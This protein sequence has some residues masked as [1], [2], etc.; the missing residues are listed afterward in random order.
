MLKKE[1]QTKHY[2]NTKIRMTNSSQFRDTER[3][4]EKGFI[5]EGAFEVSFQRGRVQ[6]VEDGPSGRG[7][8][9]KIAMRY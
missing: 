2:G 5:E 4:K 6:H 8:A 7:N 3:E 1:V 9:D